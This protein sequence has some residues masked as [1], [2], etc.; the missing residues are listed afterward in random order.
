LVTKSGTNAIHGSLYEY[1][2]NTATSANDYFIKASEIAQGLPNKPL[3]LIRNIPGGSLGGP[4]LKNRLFFFA[5][6]EA[7]RQRE[8]NSVIRVIPSDSLR[9]GILQYKDVNGGVTTLTMQDILNMDPTGLGPNPAS[10]AYFN[11]YPSPNDLSAGDGYNFVGYR[12][13]A[14]VKIDKNY[15]IGRLDYK[16]TQNGNHTLFWRG[17]AQNATNAGVPFLLGQSPQHSLTDNSKGF[18]AGYTALLSPTLVN[19]FRW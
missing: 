18:V 10:M 11:T 6:F 4:V 14:P 8:E 7:T 2:R 1:L 5:N 17:A 9:Q 19:N 3:K 15:Y 16:I 12:F 13:K